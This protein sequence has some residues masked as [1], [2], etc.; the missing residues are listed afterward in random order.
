MARIYQRRV[1]FEAF[2]MLAAV[3][4]GATGFWIEEARSRSLLLVL[5][6][7]MQTLYYLVICTGG[8]AGFY[9]IAARDPE[10]GLRVER[11]AMIILAGHT[12]CFGFANLAYASASGVPGAMML[13]GFCVACM[14]RIAQISGDLAAY[15]AYLAQAA[16]EGSP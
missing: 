16:E 4:S 7:W 10:T 12:G 1:V 11:A 8:L 5:P 3:L 9:G 6:W 14:A 13:L 2:L 15:R